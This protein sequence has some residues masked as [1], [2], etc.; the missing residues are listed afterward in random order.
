MESNADSHNCCYYPAGLTMHTHC[1]ECSLGEPAPLK[2]LGPR[3]QTK[4]R[5]DSCMQPVN[6]QAAGV[7]VPHVHCCA[8]ASGNIPVA[9]NG[10]IESLPWKGAT[11]DTVAM[12]N[13]KETIIIMVQQCTKLDCERTHHKQVIGTNTI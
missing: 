1:H 11:R 12:C 3:D 2:E 6:L 13:D 5:L 10:V 8:R 4:C 9:A 7:A